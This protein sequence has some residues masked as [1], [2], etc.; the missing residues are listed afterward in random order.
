MVTMTLSTVVG[1]TVMGWGTS[2][3]PVSGVEGT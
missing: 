1:G 2:V 3:V